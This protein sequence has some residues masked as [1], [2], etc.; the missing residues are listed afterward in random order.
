MEYKIG[1]LYSKRKKKKLDANIIMNGDYREILG[2][3]FLVNAYHYNDTIYKIVIHN[4]DFYNGVIVGGVEEL[5][6]TKYADGN[7]GEVV[8]SS[9]KDSRSQSTFEVKET[10]RFKNGSIII[11]N[12]YGDGRNSSK[13]TSFSI[14]YLDPRLERKAKLKEENEKEQKRLKEEKEWKIKQQEDFGKI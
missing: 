3:K 14:I 12:E 13:L 11:N 1:S 2:C 10:W 8:Y 4:S 5:Y 7:R 9:G 6:R